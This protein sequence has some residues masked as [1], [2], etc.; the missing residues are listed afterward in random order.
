MSQLIRI[1]PADN[2]ATARVSLE[3][4][5]EGAT[6]LIPR[7]HKIALEPIPKGAP[8]RKY[9]QLIGYAGTDIPEGGHVHTQNLEYR[10]V[11]QA[12]ETIAELRKV[13]DSADGLAGLEQELTALEAVI[14]NEPAE[15]AMD[16]IKQSERAL[17]KVAGTSPIKSK[18][19]K[20]RRAI[21]GKKPKPEKA[22][23]YIKEG[24][25][26][27]AAEVDWRRL[28]A[29]ELAPAL[30]AYDIAIKDTIGLRLQRRLPDD[31]IEEVAS[32]QS[33]HR[34][35]SLQF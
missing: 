23:R 34:D 11:D 12:Y 2:V 14:V 4:G 6:E 15:A 8:V 16:R 5:R 9:A 28:A 29:T 21:K 18:L 27:Y 19:S 7:G 22:I 31:R 26:L 24:L 32:C 30:A 35:Y 20:A 10:N 33:I 17:G 13:I 25:T 3:V 1:D